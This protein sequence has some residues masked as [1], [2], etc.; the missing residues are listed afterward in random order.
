MSNQH[1]SNITNSTI[2]VLANSSKLSSKSNLL[3]VAIIVSCIVA[4]VILFCGIYYFFH[5]TF[6]IPNAGIA[7]TIQL[8]PNGGIISSSSPYVIKLPIRPSACTATSVN[9]S[10]NDIENQSIRGS[11]YSVSSHSRQSVPKNHTNRIFN[12]N[13]AESIDDEKEGETYNKSPTDLTC[14]SIPNSF[15]DSCEDKREHSDV[16]VAGERLSEIELVDSPP[17]RAV[18]IPYYDYEY[19]VRNLPIVPLMALRKAT[20]DET[21][22]TDLP[23]VRGELYF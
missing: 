6:S 17:V 3:V 19:T 9:L 2:N 13:F 20:I 18:F 22:I 10:D 14:L 1:F 4:T 8:A 11:V 12:S 7:H 23:P 21:T 15:E 16:I 5:K